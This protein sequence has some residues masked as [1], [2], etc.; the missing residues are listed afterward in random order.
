MS[1]GVA[2]ILL[3]MFAPFPSQ[4]SYLKLT[5]ELESNSY[6]ANLI[7][8]LWS[9]ANLYSSKEAARGKF[10]SSSY[11]EAVHN[12][13]K[14]LRRRVKRLH[15]P[16]SLKGHKWAGLRHG[17]HG[18]PSRANDPENVSANG[19]GIELETPAERH[20]TDGTLGHT[21]GHEDEH[22]HFE[23]GT[24]SEGDIEDVASGSALSRSPSVSAASKK[25]DDAEPEEEIPQLSV[26]MALGLLAFVTVVS[27]FFSPFRKQFSFAEFL[28]ASFLARRRHSRIPR[29]LHRRSHRRRD[30]LRR[31]GR[32]H[33]PAHRRERRGARHGRHCLHQGQDRSQYRCRCWLE[34]PDCALRHPAVDLACVDFGQAAY[35]AFRSV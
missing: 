33:P 17:N 29:Q 5:S 14:D 24:W 18:S 32:P 15:T 19:D 34:Y 11:P 1:H 26:W 25:N 4:S 23:E 31:M 8:Q 20:A 6:I 13:A 35:A 10:Q 16:S 2:L 22:T 27:I 30:H 9:H 12:P 28:L 21:R 7:F 3:A